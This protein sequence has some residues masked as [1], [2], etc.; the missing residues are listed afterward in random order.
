MSGLACLV[1][2]ILVPFVSIYLFFLLALA[3]RLMQTVQHCNLLYLSCYPSI[4][5]SVVRDFYVS[6]SELL[7]I[8]IFSH[9][10]SCDMA[11]YKLQLRFVVYKF[12]F[13]TLTTFTSL[14]SIIV[15]NWYD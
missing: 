3:I 11:S 7:T 9:F 12:I 1:L 2:G 13:T 10:E 5:L 8:C 4:C 6:S 14:A 15:S